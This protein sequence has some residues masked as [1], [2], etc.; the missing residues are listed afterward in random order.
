MRVSKVYYNVEDRAKF[1]VSMW[2]SRSFRRGTLY[3][4][5]EAQNTLKQTGIL[6]NEDYGLDVI[7]TE[8]H[9]MFNLA[10]LLYEFDHKEEVKDDL[11]DL[12]ESLRKKMHNTQ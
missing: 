6:Y 8:E 5:E 10:L 7:F 4:S 11:V 9:P 1:L 3:L 2:R 12:L